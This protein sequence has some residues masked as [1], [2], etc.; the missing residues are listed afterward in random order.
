MG[1]DLESAKLI[2]PPGLSLLPGETIEFIARTCAIKLFETT[3]DGGFKEVGEYC[4]PMDATSEIEESQAQ[5]TLSLKFSS[6]KYLFKFSKPKPA[7]IAGNFINVRTT[8]NSLCHDFSTIMRRFV[9]PSSLENTFAFRMGEID[10]MK[11]SMDFPKHDQNAQKKLEMTL[12]EKFFNDSFGACI[13][14]DEDEDDVIKRGVEESVFNR[15]RSLGW[16]RGYKIQKEFERMQMNKDSWC[17]ASVNDDFSLS[18]TYPQELVIPSQIL[19]K[20]PSID[21]DSSS[22]SVSSDTSLNT[23][24]FFRNLARFRFRGRFPAICWKKGHNILMRSGQPMAG[25]LGSR[26]VEDETLMH[27]IL[28]TVQEEQQMLTESVLTGKAVSEVDCA[29]RC[30]ASRHFE[31]AYEP[32]N[33]KL[34]VLDARSYTAAFSNGYHGGGYENIEH[35]PPNSTLQ[36][37]GLPNIHAISSSHAALLRAINTNASSSNWYSVLESTG[38]LGH[39]AELLKAAGGKDGVVGKL[40]DEDASV[41][42][43]CTDGWDRTTQLVSLAQIMMDPFYRTIKGLQVLVEKEWISYGHPFRSRGS[44]PCNLRNNDNK[45][46]AKSKDVPPGCQK[47]PPHLPPVLA[48]VFLL[49]LTCLHNLL[50]QFTYS[51]EYND[52]LLL[53]LARAAAGNSPFGDFLCN[54]EFERET[55]RLRERTRS[56]WSWVDEHKQLFRNA[57]YQGIRPYDLIH[58][59]DHDTWND[60]SWKKDVLRPDTGARVITLWT[61]YYFPKNDYSIALLSA[62]TGTDVSITDNSAQQY[63]SYHLEFPSE[64]YLVSQFMKRRKR[65]IAEKVWTVWRSFVLEKKQVPLKYNSTTNG[66]TKKSECEDD[67]WDVLVGSEWKDNESEAPPSIDECKDK[68]RRSQV[69]LAVPQ[70]IIRDMQL[71][72]SLSS[73]LSSSPPTYSPFNDYLAAEEDD[74]DIEEEAKL[75]LSNDLYESQFLEWVHLSSQDN[76]DSSTTKILTELLREAQMDEHYSYKNI[77]PENDALKELLKEAQFDQVLCQSFCPD[78]ETMMEMLKEAQLDNP[79][80]TE[81]HSSG[82]SKISCPSSPSSAC[83]CKNSNSSENCNNSFSEKNFLSVNKFP[84]AEFSKPFIHNYENNSS[85]SDLSGEFVIV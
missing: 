47:E 84:S 82:N 43:H 58:H 25:F 45:S 1:F 63:L 65:R 14:E 71:K 74:T 23:S 18:P 80:L 9:H 26:G 41:L 5:I 69:S 52:F 56:I 76:D 33:M 22:S 64:Y 37:L 44:L 8:A 16:T 73:P 77:V 79:C 19:K 24:A 29:S 40:V 68:Q 48:P 66:G 60:H 55:V 62:P 21:S 27:D 59:N 13:S 31:E 34:C 28:L 7:A 54:S 49:F 35:Y 39:V 81:I 2:I 53:C 38:W 3:A 42:V 78:T 17:I 4:Y 20:G 46:H 75:M 15:T 51:F 72:A 50:Q 61:E 85:S 67:K 6:S 70:K 30:V 83:N 10:V 12:E 32:C 57:N 11:R 36:F